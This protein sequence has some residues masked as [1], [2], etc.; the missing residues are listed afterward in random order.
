MKMNIEDTKT[1]HKLG[2]VA[3]LMVDKASSKRALKDAV[4]IAKTIGFEKWEKITPI[5][6]NW[7]GIVKELAV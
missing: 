3:K 4:T 5:P 6:N 7:K 1:Y 2:K